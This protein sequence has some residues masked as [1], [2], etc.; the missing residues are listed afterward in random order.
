MGD[1]VTDAQLVEQSTR[2]DR[3]A[4]RA[5]VDRYQG[6]LFRLVSGLVKSKEDTEDIVQESFVKAYLSLGSFRKESTFYTWIY[7]IAH[8]MA[9][10]YK[11][12]I[13]RRGNAIELSEVERSLPVDERASPLEAV[14]RQEQGDGMQRALAKLSEEHKTV[15]I[16]REV[17]GLSYEEIAKVL[18]I[19]KGT[20]MS[21]LHYARKQLQ[22]LLK[23]FAPEGIQVNHGEISYG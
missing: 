9:I 13:A 5:L 2:G 12:K 18:G 3:E 23:D 15:I 8:N 7:R 22:E 19:S 11:R 1:T 20:V 14:V 21:R 4:F 10:D 16:L 17:D 6:K